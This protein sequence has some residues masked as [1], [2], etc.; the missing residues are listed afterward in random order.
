[1]ADESKERSE[2]DE[3]LTAMGEIVSLA[4]ESKLSE[5]FCRKP[6][7]WNGNTSSSDCTAEKPSSMCLLDVVD[8]LRQRAYG[9]LLRRPCRVS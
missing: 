2:A 3:H 1:M 6:D 5:E 7:T 9:I 4:K 8:A